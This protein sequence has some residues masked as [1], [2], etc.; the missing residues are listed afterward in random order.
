MEVKFKEDQKVIQISTRI[1]ID[2]LE[3]GLRSFIG[4]QRLDLTESADWET[5][6]KHIGSYMLDKVSVSS[7]KKS[8][9]MNYLGAEIEEDVIWAYIEIPKVRKLNKI[10]IRNEVL[11]DIFSDQENLVHFRAFGDVKSERIRLNQKVKEFNWDN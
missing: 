10:I 9:E 2:D 8:F 1:F 6:Q 3:V 4:D 5:I 7:E 11:L